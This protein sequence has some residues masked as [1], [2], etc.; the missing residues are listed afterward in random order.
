ME[1]HGYAGGSSFD[2]LRSKRP[3]DG[4][5]VTQCQKDNG[6]LEL[7]LS[8]TAPVKGLSGGL[9]LGW[10]P[11]QREVFTTDVSRSGCGVEALGG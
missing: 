10:I 6:L 11:S 1:V 5:L 8:P 2:T 9:I 4:P 7:P 3:S